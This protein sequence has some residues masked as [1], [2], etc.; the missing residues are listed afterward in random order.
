[1]GDRQEQEK[2]GYSA[3]NRSR[4]TL[5]VQL[6]VDEML[7]EGELI[8]PE[9]L[10]GIVLFA[11][12]SGSSRH[13]SRNQYV[14]GV[15]QEA[16]IATLLFDLLSEEEEFRDRKSGLVRFNIDLLSNRLLQA[17]TWI[18]KL[19]QIEDVKFGFFGASTGAAAALVAA[20]EAGK[21]AAAVVS[22]AVDAPI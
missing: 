18:V 14:A 20:S 5:N 3:E 4:Q 19:P 22:L 1:M 10:R 15:L 7:L 12:G 9:D 2:D 13:S 6:P 11:H 16:G 8:V 17:A 21:D